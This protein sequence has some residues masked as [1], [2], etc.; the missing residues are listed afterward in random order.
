MAMYSPAYSQYTFSPDHPFQPKRLDLTMELINEMNLLLLEDLTDPVPALREELLLTH[1]VDF[2]D[3]VRR[4]SQPEEEMIYDR[5][6]MGAGEAISPQKFGLGSEDTPVFPRMYEAARMV[7]GGTLKAAQLIVTGIVSHAVNFAGGLHHAQHA[8]AAGFCVFNDAAVA[9]SYLRKNYPDMKIAYVDIDA[10]HG[11][12]VQQLF[13]SDPQVLTISIHET[14][15]YLFPGTGKIKELG[16]GMGYG[17]SVNVPLEAFTEDD[18]WMTSFDRVVIPCIQ[19]FRPDLIVFQAG[20]DAHYLD[21]LT[22]LSCTTQ[23]Y[24]HASRVMHKLAHQVAGGKL[25]VLGGGGYDIWRVVPR[26][27]TLVWA[28]I[29]GRS[30]EEQVAEN[31]IEK[32]QGDSPYPLPRLMSDKIDDLPKIPRRQV[33]EEKNEIIVEQLLSEICW[34]KRKRKT[35]DIIMNIGY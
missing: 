20:C 10:H 22:H 28:E 25:L 24:S 27:W 13:Y 18:S 19:Q 15:R 17:Y 3:V 35:T 12:G 26:A 5:S 4:L 6:G 8:K 30:Y 2:I 7:V 9:I 11:D 31:W 29:A 23:I 1:H 33:I 16:E 21:P 34:L 14:G 32:F